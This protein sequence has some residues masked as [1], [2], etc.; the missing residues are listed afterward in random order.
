[1][2]QQTVECKTRKTALKRCPWAAYIVKVEDG[3]RCFESET[4]YLVWKNQK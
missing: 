2:R 1:M 3:Y 4:D